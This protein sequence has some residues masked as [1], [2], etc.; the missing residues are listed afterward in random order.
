MKKKQNNNNNRTCLG[1]PTKNQ[2]I[3]EAHMILK[4]RLVD[5]DSGSETLNLPIIAIYTAF[6]TNQIVNDEMVYFVLMLTSST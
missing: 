4:P 1:E 5:C 6:S 2:Y 3:Y